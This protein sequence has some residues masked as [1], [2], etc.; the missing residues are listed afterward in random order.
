MD[1]AKVVSPI[2]VTADAS[3]VDRSLKGEVQLT[4]SLTT[5]ASTP[6]FGAAVNGASFL[7]TL[8]PGSFVTLFGSKLALSTQLAPTVPLPTV[9]AGS[10]I[11]VAGNQIPIYYASDGQVNAILP[12]GLAV[13][14][15]QQVIVSSGSSLSVPQGITVAAAAPGVFTTTGGQ[16]IIQGIDANR[17]ATLADA[18][19]P[20]TAG[21]TIVIYCTGL[22]EVTPTLTAGTP[23]PASPLSTTVNQVTVTIGGMDAPVAFAGLT[24][25]QT[26]LYQVNAL[27]PAGAT[28]GSQ[29]P[30]VVTAA[31]QFS[32]PVTIAVR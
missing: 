29:V 24:P 3:I 12:Y 15:T 31:G 7:S 16:G 26:G 20:V 10:T 2:T 17:N 23:T 32:A 9:L 21:Q 4:G 6:I 5:T 22:G 18:S 8:S 28:T 14:T 27:V 1:S 11:Y 30:V 25:L 13:N 19:N